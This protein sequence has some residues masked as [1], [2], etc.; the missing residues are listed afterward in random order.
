[1]RYLPFLNYNF[2]KYDNVLA[3]YEGCD[4]NNSEVL[5]T[6][7]QELRKGLPDTYTP[8]YH[9]PHDGCWKLFSHF[10][11]TSLIKFGLSIGMD[12]YDM[13]VLLYLTNKPVLYVK[14]PSDLKWIKKFRKRNLHLKD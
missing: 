8:A 14:N 3:Y 2:A 13:Q 10:G 5:Y 9:I 11:R 12:L 6:R 1:M 4:A 7:I